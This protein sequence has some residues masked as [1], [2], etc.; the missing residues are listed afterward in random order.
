MCPTAW[1]NTG[2]VDDKDGEIGK[3]GYEI[4]FNRYFYQ[5]QPPRPLDEIKADISELGAGDPG[6][7]ARGG[8]MSAVPMKDSGVEWLGEMP[9][10]TGM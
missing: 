6:D 7:A 8:R 1:I 9:R 5:Y 4:N 2:V 3:V 10:H